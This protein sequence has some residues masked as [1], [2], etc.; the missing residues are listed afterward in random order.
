MRPKRLGSDAASCHYEENFMNAARGIYRRD[1]LNWC[2]N[3]SH[4]FLERRENLG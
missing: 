4:E 3:L 1:S 2:D